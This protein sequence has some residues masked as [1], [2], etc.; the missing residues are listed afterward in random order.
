MFLLIGIMVAY[1]RIEQLE[2]GKFYSLLIISIVVA[3]VANLM[4]VTTLYI[5]AYYYGK[6]AMYFA[7]VHLGW[8]IFVVVVTV[9]LYVLDKMSRVTSTSS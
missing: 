4:R 9:L 7:H 1:S 8:I 2:R 5:V 6:E 3:Y